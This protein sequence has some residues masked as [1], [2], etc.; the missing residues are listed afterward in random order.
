VQVRVSPA[1]PKLPSLRVLAR[2]G[3]PRSLRVFDLKKDNRFG[4]RRPELNLQPSTGQPRVFLPARND[5]VCSSEP[6]IDG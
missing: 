2:Q 3:L 1:G 4:Y 5:R 6:M